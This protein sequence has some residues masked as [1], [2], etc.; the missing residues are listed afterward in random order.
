[1]CRTHDYLVLLNNDV[2]FLIFNDSPDSVF[3][4]STGY[5]SLCRINVEIIQFTTG[6]LDMYTESYDKL[7]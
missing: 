3:V 7:H 1:M 6:A 2:Y 5:A 4:I